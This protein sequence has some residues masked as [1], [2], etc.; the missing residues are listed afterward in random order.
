MTKR[1]SD[2][3]IPRPYP[4]V[5]RAH[6]GPGCARDGRT[7]LTEADL[8]QPD[9]ARPDRHEDNSTG[10]RLREGDRE[11]GTRC[12]VRAVGAHRQ[13]GTRHRRCSGRGSHKGWIYDARW[14]SDGKLI[15]TAGRDTDVQIWDANTGKSVRTIEIG[16]MTPV[17]K[18]RYPTHVRMARFLN[19]DRM[20]AV[21]ADAHPV[22]IF[23]VDSGNQVAEIAY[24]FPEKYSDTAPAIA[25]TQSGL[26]VIAGSSADLIAYDVNAKS[27]RYRLKA[28]GNDWPRFAISEA[29]GLLVTTVRGKIAGGIA[30]SSCRYATLRR[31]ATLGGRGAGQSHGVVGGVLARRQAA[32]HGGRRAGIRL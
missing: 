4:D 7:R 20:L 27:E 11:V 30:A 25:A 5:T 22:Q 23:D 13:T 31:R 6:A 3:R 24:P 9:A 28:S 8:R 19:G 32:R 10:R 15:A 14:S 12:E 17:R 16:K 1:A 26:L 18:P 29:A 2:R 21:A